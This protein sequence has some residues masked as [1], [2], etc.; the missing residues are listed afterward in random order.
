MLSLLDEQAF[1]GDAPITPRRVQPY[2]VR[3]SKRV[4]IDCE[5]QAALP[6]AIDDQGRGRLAGRPAAAAQLYDDVTAYVRDGYDLGRREKNNSL[7]FL[8]LLMQ[9]LVS[10][11]TRAIEVALE[12]RSASLRVE[13]ERLKPPDRPDSSAW[14]TTSGRSDANEQLE[15]VFERQLPA[16]RQ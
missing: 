14:T 15:L 3:T 13:E 5:G 10:I 11:S 2:V 4:A 12:R 6:A 7:V 16:M 1:L 9:R 8:M